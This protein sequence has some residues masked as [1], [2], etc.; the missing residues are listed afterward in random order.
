LLANFTEVLAIVTLF[1]NNDASRRF[2]R[3]DR[4]QIELTHSASGIKPKRYPFQTA[5][6]K[7]FEIMA[8]AFSNFKPLR[9]YFI[10][11]KSTAFRGP[12]ADRRWLT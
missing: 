2:H 1:K 12:P 4:K 5:K 3:K 8:A 6:P 7:G 9:S 10:L 11:K